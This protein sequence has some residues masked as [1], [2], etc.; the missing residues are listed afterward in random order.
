MSTA[1]RI[2]P[3]LSA[4]E[5][6]L[7][8][9]EAIIARGRQS[10]YEVG[11]A[12]RTIRD[13]D[14]YLVKNGGEFKTFEAYCQSVWQWH[15]IYAHYQIS[16]AKTAENLFTMVN[17]SDL[18]ERLI[19]PLTKLDTPDEQRS[20]FRE[21]QR[22]AGEAGRAVVARD[23]AVV[24]R[25][26]KP[27][28]EGEFSSLIK[29]SDN[30]SFNPVFYGRIDRGPGH[31]YIPGEL[32]T[33]CLWYYTRPGHVVV[34][35]MAG[36]GQLW[37]VYKD[38]ARWMRPEPWKLTIRLFDLTPRGRYRKRIGQHDLRNS[39]PVSHADYIVLDVP[40]FGMV[41][42]QYSDQ[43]ADLA[44]MD[45]AAWQDS[46]ARIAAVCA[47]AQLKNGKCTVITP[48][49]C[50][51]QSG[52]RVLAPRRVQQCFERAGY[53]L[54]DIA[55]SSR[56][57]QQTQGIAMAQTNNK[58]KRERIMLTDIAEVLTFVREPRA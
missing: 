6:E 17:K 34:D 55:Y 49:F 22:L 39:F 46:I 18:T 11:C 12:L 32:Y 35:P 21:A 51:T 54:Y 16:A 30:W 44:N 45:L 20:A 57:I 42:G 3:P 41:T 29:P 27:E 15:R 14:L 28:S 48:N 10:F 4:R 24:V 26:L 19:R 25:E 36:S 40:Y 7:A 37:R 50:D 52:Q 5:Q 56:Y 33:N 13:N 23:V 9:C 2:V 31:G 8:A 1:L 58:A 38:R 43:A 47:S 53:Q